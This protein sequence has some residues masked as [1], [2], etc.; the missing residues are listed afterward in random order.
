LQQKQIPFF[1]KIKNLNKK[2]EKKRKNLFFSLLSLRRCEPL[3]QTEKSGAASHLR[4]CEISV[5]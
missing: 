1:E 5:N 4:K 2:K 3:C